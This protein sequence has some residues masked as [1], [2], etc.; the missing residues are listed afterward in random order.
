MMRKEILGRFYSR[1]KI[2][3]NNISIGSWSGSGVMNDCG[4][5]EGKFASSSHDRTAHR[6]FLLCIHGSF[7]QGRY[8]PVYPE[9]S[10]AGHPLAGR[11]A[12]LAVISKRLV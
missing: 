11:H 2:D 4:P 5:K 7:C 1:S 10:L 3:T 9:D 6:S 12:L 8:A